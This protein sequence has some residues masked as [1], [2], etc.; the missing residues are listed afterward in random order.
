M[1]RDKNKVKSFITINLLI[2]IFINYQSIVFLIGFIIK[3]FLFLLNIIKN[4]Y[5]INAMWFYG[6]SLINF[7]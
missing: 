1:T 4:Y 7:R 6:P 3:L 2:L 5:L